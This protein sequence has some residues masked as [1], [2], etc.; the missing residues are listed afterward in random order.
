[1]SSVLPW[2]D[3]GLPTKD[4]TVRMIA[5][6]GATPLFWGRDTSARCLLIIELEGDHT[7]EYRRSVVE[8]HGIGVDL[9][10]V[11]CRTSNG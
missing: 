2:D 11:K 5:S 4:Y 7:A 9:A 6:L 10:M 8:I 3:I 1:M